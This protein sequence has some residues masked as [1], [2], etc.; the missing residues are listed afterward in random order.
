[1]YKT[2][3]LGD[4]RVGIHHRH[5]EIGR[6][7]CRHKSRDTGLNLGC[8]NSSAPARRTEC[9][10]TRSHLCSTRLPS[11]PLLLLRLWCQRLTLPF[12]HPGLDL[13]VGQDKGRKGRYWRR[14]T[15]KGRTGW[16]RAIWKSQL[17]RAMMGKGSR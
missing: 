10:E 5:Q 17:N 15:S 8:T 11:F 3:A 13:S 4:S 6:P 7:R 16:R 2:H 14:R 9:E 12:L 1:M